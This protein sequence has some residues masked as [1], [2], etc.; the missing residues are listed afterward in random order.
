MKTFKQLIS[1]NTTAPAEV[2]GTKQLGHLHHIE[3]HSFLNG[4]VGTEH[5]LNTLREMHN[6]LSGQKSAVKI[7]TKYDGAPSLVFGR[8]PKGHPQEGKYFVAT[9][10]IHNANPKIN[11]TPEDIVQN[12]GHAPGLVEKLNAALEHIPKLDLKHGDMYQGDVM[13]T[14]P[15]VREDGKKFSFTPNTLTYSTDKNSEEGKKIGNAKIGIA[16]HTK[17]EGDKTGSLEGYSARFMPD[18]SKLKQHPDVHIISTESKVRPENY[19]PHQRAEFERHMAIA[20]DIHDSMDESSHSAIA[21]HSDVISTY[22]NTEVRRNGVPNHKDF[23]DYIDEKGNK[24]ISKLKSQ[25]A[26]DRKTQLHKAKITDIK[27]NKAHFDKLFQLHKHLQSAKDILASAANNNETYSNSI[28]GVPSEG[29]G[30][31]VVHPK[32][33]IIDKAVNRS[34]FSAANFAKAKY[35]KQPIPEQ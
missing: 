28:D 32:Q 17:Y 6:H 25:S 7:G 33:N 23:V 19:N 1:E 26:I 31:V 3:D 18:L 27:K 20:K 24:E 12:H 22:I 30:S 34:R 13:Y 8:M 16:V 35:A 10:S 11:Y 5:A 15:D 29:E 14:K 21:P 4:K 2:E 9:K